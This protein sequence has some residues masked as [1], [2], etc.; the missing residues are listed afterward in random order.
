MNQ[1]QPSFFVHDFQQE[2]QH[3]QQVLVYSNDFQQQQSTIFTQDFTQEQPQQLTFSPEKQQLTDM[4]TLKKKRTLE[5]S[6]MPQ[7][8]RQASQPIIIDGQFQ[9]FFKNQTSTPEFDS[10]VHL[11]ELTY[12]HFKQM[13]E[14]E[15]KQR[16]EL[17]KLRREQTDFQ[18]TIHL[19]IS[20]NNNKFHNQC[21]SVSVYLTLLFKLCQELKIVEP[22]TSLYEMN[23][24]FKTYTSNLKIIYD[25][26]SKLQK[27]ESSEKKSTS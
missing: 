7:I 21:N 24:N 23:G 19:L 20:E 16:S 11:N 27:P 13:K 6:F 1:P 8:K 17:D 4:Q 15:E 12:Q 22:G 10:R 25:A 5:E 2:Q 14:M 9:S 26:L 3:C 18:N